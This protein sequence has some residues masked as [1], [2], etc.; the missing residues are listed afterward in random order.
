MNRSLGGE[1]EINPNHVLHEQVNSLQI[2]D[3]SFYSSGRAAL[4]DLLKSINPLH[5]ILLPSYLCE[6]ILQPI[7]ELN[8]KYEFY[9]IDEEIKID[10]D[11]LFKRLKS[12]KYS[13]ILCIDYFGHIDLNQYRLIRRMNK[14]I[15]IIEDC[16]H[17]SFIPAILKQYQYEGDYVFGSLRKILPIADGGFVYKTGKSNNHNYSSLPDNV[18]LLK[19]AAKI[20]RYANLNAEVFDEDLERIYLKYFEKSESLLNAEIKIHDMSEISKALINNMDFKEIAMKRRRNYCTL[21]RLFQNSE[22]VTSYFNVLIKALN[23]GDMP[24]MFP[25]T[26]KNLDRN[27]LRKK[28]K[29]NKIYTSVIWDLPRELKKRAYKESTGLSRNIL[30]FPIDQRY[31]TNEIEYL[32]N[33]FY[34]CISEK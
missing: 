15:L 13:L 32:F 20:M 33:V 18:F 4:K 22:K 6:S 10:I 14:D 23:P 21:Q 34:R 8:L 24:Y 31:E 5:P 12:Q 2:V 11:H 16:T 27:D 9:K 28:L 30:C 7:K 29:D 1:L 17:L 25:V 26:L 3:Y 19:Y